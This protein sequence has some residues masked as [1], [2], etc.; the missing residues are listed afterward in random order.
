MRLYKKSEGITVT[1]PGWLV[2]ILEEIC[3]EQD[4]S[5]SGFIKKAVKAHLLHCVANKKLWQ[6]IYNNV[7]EE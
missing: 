6:Q 2:E 3:D 7:M 1:L 4:M 5:K